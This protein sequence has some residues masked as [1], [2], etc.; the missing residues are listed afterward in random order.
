ME[1]DRRKENG[2]MA[3]KGKKDKGSVW[4]RSC[5]R[6]LLL[7]MALLAAVWICVGCSSF[8][9]AERI[10]LMKTEGTVE[11]SNSR[12][13]EL[14]PVPEMK[15]YSGYQVATEKAS[16]A[17]LNLDSVKL[18]KMDVDSQISVAKKRNGLEVLVDSGN[19]YFHIKEPLKEDETLDIRTSNLSVGIRGTCGWVEVADPEHMKVYILEGT[20][21]CTVDAP[22][23]RESKEASVSGG[24]MAELII[25]LEAEEGEQCKVEVSRFTEK[26]IDRFVWEELA[27]DE[28]LCAAVKEESGLDILDPPPGSHPDEREPDGQGA[29]G[30]NDQEAD[31][32]GDRLA[33]SMFPEGSEAAGAKDPGAIRRTGPGTM[34]APGWSFGGA[35]MED[36]SLW[37]WGRGMWGMDLPEMRQGSETPIKVMD[38]ISAVCANVVTGIHGDVPTSMTAAI[39]LDGSLWVWGDGVLGDGLYSWDRGNGGPVKVMEDVAAVSMGEYTIAAV[40]TDGSLWMWGEDYNSGETGWETQL[41]PVK[42]ME[43]VAAVSICARTV[44]VVK[45]DGSLWMWGN[46]R[47]GRLGNGSTVF[48]REPV[49]VMKD[50]AAVSVSETH[51]GAVKTDGSLWMWGSD[52]YGQL[53]DGSQGNDRYSGTMSDM[54]GSGQTYYV[55]YP[56][57]TV[58]VQVLD[59]VTAVSTGKYSTA[60][61][62]EDGSLWTWGK[63]VL[64]ENGMGNKS[65]GRVWCGAPGEAEE[66]WAD[67]QDVPAKVM[68]DVAAVNCNGAGTMAVKTDGTLWM[69]GTNVFPGSSLGAQMLRSPTKVLDG[70]AVSAE[71]IP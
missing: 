62:R 20:V 15:L 65:V 68:E 69:W 66:I 34:L 25:D 26:D 5:S 7:C 56:I 1:E 52:E 4:R 28:A 36:R 51:T 57:Q 22:R 44:A 58:P 59:Q 18:A 38:G 23:S 19:L 53:G 30:R 9:T 29:D 13:K 47:D 12:G 40:K 2:S 67:I 32:S 55:D 54:S 6:V 39:D 42:V 45:T 24:Q 10:Q 48:L 3:D 21:R 17:W 35:V 11:I 16:Y 71:Q 46:G 63:D 8:Y 33:V 43:D 37:M 31:G 64:Y 70:V 41:S 50:V 61:I 27:E 49:K 60:A 14:E